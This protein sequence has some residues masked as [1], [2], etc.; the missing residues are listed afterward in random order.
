MCVWGMGVIDLE[1]TQWEPSSGTDGAI[2]TDAC[3]T[4]ATCWSDPVPTKPFRRGT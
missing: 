3:H 1:Y 4:R 2:P